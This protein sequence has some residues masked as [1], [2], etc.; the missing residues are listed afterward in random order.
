MTSTEEIA[1]ERIAAAVSNADHCQIGPL[2]R[3]ILA[4]LRGSDFFGGF[5]PELTRRA[6]F[7]AVFFLGAIFLTT[8]F[9]FTT[10][11]LATSH[12]LFRAGNVR[13]SGPSYDDPSR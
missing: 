6:V 10:V 13:V 2:G 11:F 4:D 7:I 12:P 8:L 9:F 1:P 5:T 3:R